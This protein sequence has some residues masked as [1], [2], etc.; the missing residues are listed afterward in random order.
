MDDTI[1]VDAYSSNV[2]EVIVYELKFKRPDI[3]DTLFV[4]SID[5]VD[6]VIDTVIFH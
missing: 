6:Q 1:K 5:G 3:K 4:V 2:D